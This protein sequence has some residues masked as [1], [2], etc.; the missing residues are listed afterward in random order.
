M[1]RFTPNFG[2]AP[3]CDRCIPS[4][5]LYSVVW[6][7]ADFVSSRHLHAIYSSLFRLIPFSYYLNDLLTLIGYTDSAFKGQLNVGLTCWNLINGVT[8]SLLVMRFKRRSMYMVCTISLLCVYVGW[9]ISMERF[10]TLQAAATAKLTIF[11]I[12]AYQPAYNIGYNALTYST[13]PQIR[14]GLALSCLV[15]GVL[16]N[17]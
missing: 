4:R 5:T 12:F 15:G 1:D 9:T 3:P 16:T 2:D 14:Y 6:K 13:F 7:Y 11:F 8:I 10:M 17:I